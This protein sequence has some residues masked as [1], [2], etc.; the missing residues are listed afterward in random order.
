MTPRTSRPSER[1]KTC[2]RERRREE[3]EDGMRHKRMF[4][5][6]SSVV[7]VAHNR[8]ARS[9]VHVR[10]SSRDRCPGG[11][12][13]MRDMCVAVRQLYI[14]T[15]SDRIENVILCRA[16]VA[17]FARPISSLDGAR[18]ALGRR[19]TSSLPMKKATCDTMMH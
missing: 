14:H 16:W 2:M 9:V 3:T 11:Q 17:G 6:P 5:D 15:G 4:D 12:H 19:S 13:R 7:D 10:D 18:D 1:R 8:L